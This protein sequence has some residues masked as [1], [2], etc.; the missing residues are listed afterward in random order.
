MSRNYIL[1]YLCAVTPATLNRNVVKS[2]EIVELLAGV[3]VLKE[4]YS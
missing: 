4:S 3:F 1:I 2:V